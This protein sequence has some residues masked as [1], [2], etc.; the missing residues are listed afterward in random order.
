M[1]KNSKKWNIKKEIRTAAKLLLNLEWWKF[2]NS[3]WY[4]DRLRLNIKYISCSTFENI[5]PTD[6]PISRTIFGINL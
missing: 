1:I 4:N 2:D 3:T 5:H 6:V